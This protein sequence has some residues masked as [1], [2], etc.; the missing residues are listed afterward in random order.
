VRS[1]GRASFLLKSVYKQSPT[2][3]TEDSVLKSTGNFNTDVTTLVYSSL[4]TSAAKGSAA[5]KEKQ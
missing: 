2:R 1:D 4:D 5:K 3:Y